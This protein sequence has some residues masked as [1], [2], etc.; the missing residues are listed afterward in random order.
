TTWDGSKSGNRY[1]ETV[2]YL[3]SHTSLNDDGDVT[4]GTLSYKNFGEGFKTTPSEDYESDVDATIQIIEG[5]RDIISEVA[6]SKIGLPW[7]GQD[8]S[9]IESPYA[10]NSIIDFYDN[11]AGCKNALYGQFDATSPTENSLIYFCLNSDNTTLK[12]QAQKVQTTLD[13]ALSK[14][15]NMKAPFALNYTDSSV[16]TA[17]DAL[18]ALDEALDAME[19][20]LKGYAGN[21]TVEAQCKVINANYVDN[22][23]VKTYTLLC[24]EAEKL[25]NSIK[26]IKK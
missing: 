11:I 3:K 18:N 20:T 10:Y 16:K 14:I 17:I 2:N 24:D 5:A 6:G 22:V 25:Y 1:N 19:S 7:S 21:A 23:V 12:S 13:D 9:Y 4:D 15:N 8:N 26:N